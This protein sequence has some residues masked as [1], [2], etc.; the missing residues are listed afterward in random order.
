MPQ[1]PS[2]AGRVMRR[3]RASRGRSRGSYRRDPSVRGSDQSNGKGREGPGRPSRGG[4]PGRGERLSNGGSDEGAVGP[5]GPLRPALPTRQAMPAMPAGAAKGYSGGPCA[6]DPA[7]RPRSP[8]AEA[9][10]LK[11]AQCRFESDRGHLKTR[12]AG[13]R[14]PE[15]APSA[16]RAAVTAG[17]GRR[18]DPMSPARPAR[19][20]RDRRR[21][22]W[23]CRRGCR[24][25]RC[26][27]S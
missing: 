16:P 21:S 26:R 1:P 8:T 12:P 6:V 14:A 24:A 9:S 13:R 22:T 2:S 15:R 5:A 4:A 7:R 23:R 10:D 20:R 3:A 27:R 25:P 11:S 18:A 19:V 17:I